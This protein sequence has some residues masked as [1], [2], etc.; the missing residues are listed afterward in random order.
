MNLSL[1]FQ[2]SM[3]S[4]PKTFYVVAAIYRPKTMFKELIW[5]ESSGK[6]FAGFLASCLICCVGGIWRRIN[7]AKK[8]YPPHYSSPDFLGRIWRDK[9]ARRIIRRIAGSGVCLNVK[10]EIFNKSKLCY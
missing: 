9:V 10:S 6:A 8:N 3:T 4:H 1:L 5:E 2:Q 7:P